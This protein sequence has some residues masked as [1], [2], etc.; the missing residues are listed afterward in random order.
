MEINIVH[1]TKFELV[2]LATLTVF[3]V[4]QHNLLMMSGDKEKFKTFRNYL[5]SKFIL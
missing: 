2:F 3:L 4:V 5:N 1:E